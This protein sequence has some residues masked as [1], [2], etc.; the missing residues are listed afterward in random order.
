MELS[1]YSIWAAPLALALAVA[2]LL[3]RRWVLPLVLGLAGL[4]V[5]GVI[6]RYAWEWSSHPRWQ[7]FGSDFLGY[8]WVVGFAAVGSL[9]GA[10]VGLGVSAW[11]HRRRVDATRPNHAAAA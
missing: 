6:G 3:A 5:G 4:P 9:V 2:A 1:E 8:D 10:L 11:R 7:E